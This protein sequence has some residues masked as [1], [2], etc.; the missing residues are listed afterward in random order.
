MDDGKKTAI[1]TVNRMWEVATDLENILAKYNQ[2][3]RIINSGDDEGKVLLTQLL[4][5]IPHWLLRNVEIL[6]EAGAE[7]SDFYGINYRPLEQRNKKE[8]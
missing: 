8:K 4:K 3:M 1:I 7:A 5:D 2:Y 6:R